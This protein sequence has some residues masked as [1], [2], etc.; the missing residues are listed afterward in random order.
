[1]QI[2]ETK[3]AEQAEH[4]HLL[5]RG[6]VFLGFSSYDRQVSKPEPT[7]LPAA[8]G[9]LTEPSLCLLW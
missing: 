9:F 5:G 6:L 4:S 8:S 1:M 7:L 2:E 3:E